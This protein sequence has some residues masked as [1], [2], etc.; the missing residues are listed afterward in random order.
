[1]SEIFVFINHFWLCA[2]VM[3]HCQLLSKGLRPLCYK[4]LK[5]IKTLRVLAI[6]E[7]FNGSM[8]LQITLN[9]QLDKIELDLPTIFIWKHCICVYFVQPQIILCQSG[10]IFCPFS[11]MMKHK[12]KNNGYLYCIKFQWFSWIGDFF[13]IW[14][15][16]SGRVCSR[17][18]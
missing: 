17:W 15:V 5:R 11:V 1:M 9:P 12:W 14:V 3:S 8:L 10:P 6:S 7:N 16:V 4:T 13:Y 2:A 18:C